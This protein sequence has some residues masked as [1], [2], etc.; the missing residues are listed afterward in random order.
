MR[1]IARAASLAL[2]VALTVSSADTVAIHVFVTTV[3]Q[4]CPVQIVGF[5]LPDKPGGVPTVVVHNT[6]EKEVKLFR[7]I[8]LLGDPK[9]VG[10]DSPKKGFTVDQNSEWE[11]R[12]PLIAPN[13]DAE[14]GLEYLTSFSLAFTAAH[15]LHSNCLQL[16]LV[17]GG[18]EFSDGTVWEGN[19]DQHTFL[20]RNSIRPRYLGSCDSSPEIKQTLKQIKAASYS[21]APLARPNAGTMR[22]YS[23]ACPVRRIG[24]DSVAVC[25]W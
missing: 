3:K 18:V 17:L 13:G 25:D 19:T 10:A 14:F 2:F 8:Y 24:R 9:G 11:R 16:A 23:V 12:E 7:L 4:D 15:S 22:F 1:Q 21:D 20:W 6:T 5:K